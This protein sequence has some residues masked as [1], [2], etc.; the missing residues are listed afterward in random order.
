MDVQGNGNTMCLILFAYKMHPRYQ[1]VLAANRDEF[2]DRPTQGLSYWEDVPQ[3]LA[4][5]DL[6][7]RGTW[8]GMTRVRSPGRH[9]EFQGTGQC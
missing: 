4:G 7:A 2:Y 3:V 1:L 8:L 6:K 5:R 9:H